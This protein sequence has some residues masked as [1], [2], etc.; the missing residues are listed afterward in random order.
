[1]MHTALVLDTESQST[2][3]SKIDVPAGYEPRCHHTTINLGDTTEGPAARFLGRGFEIIVNSIA[4]DEKVIAV[5]V[6][7]DCPSLN[8]RPHITVAVNP[9]AGGRSMDSNQL[10]DW[11]P[12]A[13]FALHGVVAECT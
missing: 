6:K 2:L 8:A 11:K 9:A 7:T 1:M 10:R 13:P 5:G 12:I 4:S 3:R